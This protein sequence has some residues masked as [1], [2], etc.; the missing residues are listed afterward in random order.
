VDDPA[1]EFPDF[2]LT[3]PERQWVELLRGMDPETRSAIL[4]ISRSLAETR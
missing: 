4:R 1:A 2:T 3:A